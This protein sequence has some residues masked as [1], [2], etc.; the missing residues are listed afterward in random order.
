MLDYQSLP[1]DPGIYIYRNK[2]GEIIYIGKA[3]N[4]KKRVSQYFQ[5]DDALGPKTAT[6]V[7]QIAHIDYQIVGSE[8]EALIL[9]SSLIKKHQP[10]YNSL[11]TDDKGYLY[12]CITRESIP[13]IFAAQKT[14]IPANTDIYG[15]F[16]SAGSVRTLL[17][18]IRRIFPYR[19][20]ESHPKTNCLYCHLHL[21]PGPSPDQKTYRQTIGKIKKILN[22][23]FKSL[24]RQLQHQIKQFSQIE[25]F[26]S[27]IIARNQLA[28]INYVVSGWHH[29][30]ALYEKID[31]PEDE[32]SKAI[33]ELKTLLLPY[34]SSLS[35]LNRIEAFDI[36]QLG[37]HYFVGSMTV[38]QNGRLDK[39]QYRKFKIY[40]QQTPDDQLMIKEIV[41]RRLQHPEWGTPDLILVDGGKP[42]VTAASAVILSERRES[43]DLPFLIGLAKKFETIILKTPDRWVEINLPLRSSALRLLQQLRDEA[44]RFANSYR[45]LLMKKSINEN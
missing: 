44:H 17:R 12:I 33:S 41:F 45:R 1:S 2:N 29:L 20:L 6:L 19:S 25:N 15:P 36:S 16:P 43:K 9:E 21:C 34:C 32:S 37:H 31:L 22:G 40:S 42:Q 13:R 28:A 30:H 26:E 35:L 39:S 10:K 4:L 14:K 27:A 7:S 5:R 8:I 38:F 24:Q 23:N 11:L 18:I 3:V